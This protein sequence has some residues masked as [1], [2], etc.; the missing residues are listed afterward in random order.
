MHWRGRLGGL[1]SRMI[2]TGTGES[3]STN[4][5]TR[6]TLLGPGS[7]GRFADVRQDQRVGMQPL[8]GGNDLLL[9]A[10]PSDE[11]G[12]L[13]L[14]GIAAANR[15]CQTVKSAAASSFIGVCQAMLDRVFFGSGQWPRRTA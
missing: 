10:T 13:D 15:P 6:P 5:A 2:R 1:D 4:R 11:V 7:V 8:G 9:R 14:P 3:S 12:D